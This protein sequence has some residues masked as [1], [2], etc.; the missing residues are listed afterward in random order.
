M[1]KRA[2]VYPDFLVNCWVEVTKIG[3]GVEQFTLWSKSFHGP[4][5]T[6]WVNRVG[7]KPV[8][9]QV[10]ESYVPKWCRRLGVRTRLNQELFRYCDV[11]STGPSEKEGRA[12]MKSQGYTQ[13]T[14]T[15]HWRLSKPVKWVYEGAA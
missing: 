1:P 7:S 4:V 6:V 11:I 5:G 12:F 2:K 9:A 3:F 15:K 14:V 8:V 10:I 13:D